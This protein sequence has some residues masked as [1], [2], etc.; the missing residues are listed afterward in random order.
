MA[1]ELA[2]LAAPSHPPDFQFERVLSLA[3]LTVWWEVACEVIGRPHDIVAVGARCY[4]E[5]GPES[6]SPLQCYVGLLSG[7]PVATACLV[8]GAGVA[9]LYGVGTLPDVRCRGIGTAMTLSA[10]QRAQDMGCRLAVLRASAQGAPLY[11][12]LGFREYCRINT[13]LWE[14]NT[15]DTGQQVE[16]NG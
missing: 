3:G 7:R 8:L 10:L 11:R 12:R 13:Y 9:G 6:D 4:T 2:R 1:V 15:S 16:L 14:A 5:M